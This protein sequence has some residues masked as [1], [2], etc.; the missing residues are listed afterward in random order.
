MPSSEHFKFLSRRCANI[1]YFQIIF[2]FWLKSLT[3]RCNIN[4]LVLG[5]ITRARMSSTTES[6]LPVETL[7]VHRSCSRSERF[8]NGTPARHQISDDQTRVLPNVLHQN[9]LTPIWL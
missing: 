2:I 5:A 4:T 8:S 6:E 9:V 1:S 7:R 3:S